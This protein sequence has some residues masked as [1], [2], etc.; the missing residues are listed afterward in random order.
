MVVAEIRG[1]KTP[2][3]ATHEPLSRR[4]VEGFHLVS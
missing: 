1:R 3:M 4:G 2:I